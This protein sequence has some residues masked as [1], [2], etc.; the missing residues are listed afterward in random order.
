MK[1]I[2]FC[3]VLF[4]LAFSLVACG[5]SDAVMDEAKTYE[6]S[7]EIHS[8]IIEL[9][10]AD[11]VIQEATDFSVESNLKYLSVTEKNGV[12]RIVDE[13][14][15]HG[16]YK[17]D[18][19]LTLS[20]PSGTNF[21]DVDIFTGAA[22]MTVDTLSAR[23]LDLKL[24]AGDVRIGALYVN[25]E[26][27]IDG[28]AGA[29]TILDGEIS[30]LDLQMGVGALNVAVAL[31]GDNDLEFGVGESNLTLL[32]GKEDYTVEIDK[33]L[34]SITVDGKSVSD[35]GSGSGENTVDIEGGVG[36]VHLKFSENEP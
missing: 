4:L 16:N 25:S 11:F 33:G 17:N 2:L 12:L 29:I 9:N 13:A 32:G 14:N 7:S 31:K 19:M 35:F 5:K 1:K 8:L 28:G 27:D 30:N 26:A 21:R 20:V 10:A 3:F 15:Q 6:I 24:G 18:P 22:K 34:G 23:S 36:S